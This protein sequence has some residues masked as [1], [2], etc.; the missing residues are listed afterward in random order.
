MSKLEL[1]LKIAALSIT[2]SLL[3]GCDREVNPTFDKCTDNNSDQ[4]AD[5][6]LRQNVAKSSTH[7]V[8]GENDFQRDTDTGELIRR[9]GNELTVMSANSFI[10]LPVQLDGRLYNVTFQD[11]GPYIKAVVDT[12]CAK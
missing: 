9:N 10:P 8:I 3:A 11:M 2:G 4:S 1:G 12:S 7:L 6:F 5:F